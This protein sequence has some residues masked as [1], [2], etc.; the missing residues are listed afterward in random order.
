[1]K[2]KYLYGFLGLVIGIAISFTWTRSYN[3]ANAGTMPKTTT[4]GGAGGP[5]NSSAEQQ[6]TMGDIAKTIENAKN[7]PKDFNAQV[8]AARA[9]A[10]IRQDEKAVGFLEKAY[11]ADAKKFTE[12]KAAGYVGQFY[13]E[14]KKYNEA[15][16]WFNRALIEDPNEPDLHTMIAETFM[17]RE[18]AQPDKAIPHIQSALKLD[19]KNAHAMGHL[20]EAYALKK[21]ASGA[22]DALNKLKAAEPTNNR[23]AALQAM[24][25]DLKAGKPV[26]IPK[27]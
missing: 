5:G 3:N 27:E 13:F 12:L 2:K 17:N 4:A 23:I 18:P 25:A 15:E 1:M 14:Q 7:N 11:D 24:I 22:E 10:Q 20:V 21:D 26:I 9:F 16:T 6:A 8:E 19:A